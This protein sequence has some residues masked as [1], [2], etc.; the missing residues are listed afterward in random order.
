MTLASVNLRD[1]FANRPTA[2]IAGRSFFATDTNTL[3]RDNGASWDFIATLTVGGVSV[4]SSAYTLVATD[5]L[6]MI[7]A[8]SS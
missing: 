4:K 2:G 1:I 7:V 3:Y 6:T 8:N 5:N